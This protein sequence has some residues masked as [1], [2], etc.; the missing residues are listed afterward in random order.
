MIKLLLTLALVVGTALAGFSILAVYKVLD[1]RRL[2]RFKHHNHLVFLIADVGIGSIVYL[3]MWIA[4]LVS[5]RAEEFF[6][7]AHIAHLIPI[8]VLLA[9]LAFKGIYKIY[10]HIYSEKSSEISE[11]NLPVQYHEKHGRFYISPYYSTLGNVFKYA[12]VI[13]VILISLS[14]GI[15]YLTNAGYELNLAITAEALLLVPLLFMELYSYFDGLQENDEEADPLIQETPDDRDTV[16]SDLDK[17][18]YSLWQQQLLGRYNVTNRYERHIIKETGKDDD[19]SENIAKSAAGNSSNDFLYSR[20]LSPVMR[21]DNIIIESCYLQ[22]FSDIIFPIVN[23]MFTASKHM[24]FVCDNYSTVKQCEK[25]FEAL[26]I[27]S[28]SASSNIVIDV[29]SYDNSESIQMDSNVDIYIGTVDLALNSKAIFENIDVVFCLNVD[30]MISESALNLNLLAS[31]LSADRYDDVQYILF[32]NRVNGLKQTVSQ[33]F[34]RNDFAY[35][36]VNSTIEKNLSANFW[37]TEKGWYQSAILPGFASQYLGQLIPLAVPAFKFGIQHVDVI[38][39]AQSFTD[40]MQSLQM[41]QPLLKNYMGKDIVNIDEAIS[42]AENE[43][44]I[45]LQDNSVVV[46]GDNGNNAALVLLNWLKYAKSNMFLNVVSAP[47]LLRDYIVANMDFFI[48]NVEAIGN[49]LPVPKSNIKLSVYRL[50]NQLCYGHVAEETLLREIKNQ[51]ADLQINTFE[52]DQVRFVTEALQSLTKR[53]FG[54]N[55]F[56]TSYLTSHRVNRDQSMEDKRY[57]KLLDSIKSELPERLFKNI[58]FIDSEQYAKVLKR[59]PVFELY[60]NYLEGQYVSF[61]NKYYLIDKI[62]YDNGIVELTYSSNNASVRYRQCRQISNVVHHGIS[63]ELPTLN[64]RNSVLKKNMLRADIEVNTD[65]YYEFN[66]A[67]S[68]VPGGFGYKR[69]DAKKKG[70]RRV[71]KA[72]NVLAINITSDTINAMSQQDK[73]RLSFTLSVLFNEIFET[74][75]SNIKQYIL[76]R[77]VVSDSSHYGAYAEEELINLY[78]PIIDPQVED[79]INLYITEDT[80][81]EKGITDTIVNHFDNIIMRLLFDYL[82]WLLAE[83]EDNRVKKW[84]ASDTGDFINVESMDKLLFLK[85]GLDHVNEC[86]DLRAALD[87]LYELI[88]TGNDTLTYSRLGF[89]RH[90]T[91][92]DPFKVLVPEQPAEPEAT[93]PAPQQTQPAA[94]PAPAPAA[95]AAP[96]AAAPAAPATTASAAS[97]SDAAAEVITEETPAQSEPAADTAEA[98]NLSQ[99]TAEAAEEAP[100]APASD[101]ATEAPETADATNTTESV[102]TAEQASEPTPTPTPVVASQETPTTETKKSWNPFKIFKRKNK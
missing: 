77:S 100:A 44:F 49:I 83:K 81:L 92:D 45:T 5:E 73:F 56:F 62:D 41:A 17:E 22:S 53:A 50:I 70:L 43:N 93:Q 16:W 10:F 46:V 29:L 78:R 54:T 3:A 14:I 51:D 68:F 6:E 65:G 79:G 52:N 9:Y 25:W 34:M 15:A 31:V 63:K 11:D 58:T 80:E 94:A 99:T 61:N 59:I 37:S 85:Y 96:V 102:E 27:K 4:S 13:T 35:Q 57:Y 39:P 67:I 28:N 98:E 40:Q 76:V 21:G 90:R 88:L 33:V 7:R 36:V 18:Y 19:L 91:E 74:L 69:V 24:M 75:F 95:P 89:I 47:Y 97:E 12:T 1:I 86:L 71:Y 30:R 23:V 20:I 55:I 66:N 42:F 87:C 26:E 72:T 101:A 32:G 2:Y 8:L 82:Y 48:G 60:Q 84:F 38:S 64:V